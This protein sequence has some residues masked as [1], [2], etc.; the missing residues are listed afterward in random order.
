M[1][2]LSLL[3]AL[4]SL[5]V[6][7]GWESTPDNK[8]AYTI[9]IE[10]VLLD[11]LRKGSAIE[12]QVD[13]KDRGL[14]SFRVAMGPKSPNERPPSA[15]NNEVQYGWRPNDRGGMDYYVQLSPERLETLAKGIPLECEVNSAVPSVERIYV[16]V[17][18]AVLPREGGLATSS[19]VSGTNSPAV[20]TPA[21]SSAPAP[22][23]G[24]DSRLSAPQLPNAAF[25]S[26]SSPTVGGLSS[27]PANPATVGGLQGGNNYSNT[28]TPPGSNR[29]SNE[30]GPGS[31]APPQNIQ[32]PGG[33]NASTPDPYGQLRG[34]LPVPDLRREEPRY[35]DVY[36]YRDDR[37]LRGET[38]ARQPAE[39]ASA[40]APPLTSHPAAPPNSWPQA[41]SP[42]YPGYAQAPPA[43]APTAAPVKE[44]EIVEVKPWTPLVL[45]TL[46]LFASIGANAYLGWL[47]WSFFWRYRDTASGLARA[48]SSTAG[49]RQA[50]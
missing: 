1:N 40:Y 16:F 7:V 30:L 39:P 11:Q 29:W 20:A 49:L 28:L 41:P 18:T 38:V 33:Y 37:T 19:T 2:G 13:V 46:A 3:V 44:K 9:R 8:L 21:S 34:T 22:L 14:R 10:S 32:P 36:G 35:Q 26:S 50:A 4:A 15:T 31:S 45:T 17:G 27:V 43:A 6:D 42:A 48:R 23:T 24:A 12:S 47:A 5:G 25:G